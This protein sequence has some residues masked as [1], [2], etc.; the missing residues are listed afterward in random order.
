M[1]LE[2]PSLSLADLQAALGY[3]FDRLMQAYAEH[4]RSRKIRD[5]HELRD[6]SPPI[7][8]TQFVVSSGDIFTVSAKDCK[9]GV[10]AMVEAR[11]QVDEDMTRMGA[12]HGEK[13]QTAG[14]EE[15]KVATAKRGVE[16]CEDAWFLVL[17]LVGLAVLYWVVHDT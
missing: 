9:R 4:N 12:G 7:P 11:L 8:E 15:L 16:F 10:V 14:K 1:C 13:K 2:H 5:G 6:A 17:I 3:S